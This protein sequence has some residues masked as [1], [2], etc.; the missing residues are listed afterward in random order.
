MKRENY[1]KLLYIICVLFI[2]G[3]GVSLW[4]DYEKY[5]MYALPFYYY[6]IFRCIEFLVPGIIILIVARVLKR[7]LK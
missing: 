4:V 7:K 3:F 5:L 1:P 6:I 2:V